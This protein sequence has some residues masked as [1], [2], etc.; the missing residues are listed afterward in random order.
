MAKV[1]AEF[2][3]HSITDDF[4]NTV[5]DINKTIFK[6][7]KFWKKYI[8]RKKCKNRKKLFNRT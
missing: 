1:T 2:Y 8:D 6:K 7:S 4:D 3:P 5:K